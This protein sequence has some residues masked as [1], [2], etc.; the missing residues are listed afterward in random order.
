MRA[1]QSVKCDRCCILQAYVLQR[2]VKGT[3]SGQGAARQGFAAALACVLRAMP[4]IPVNTVLTKIDDAL[5]ASSSM[6]PSVR[7]FG[8]A[9]VARL[10]CGMAY[11]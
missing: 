11:L 3:G 10:C 7:T 1:C 8:T 6:K 5:A 4:D 9:P 2:L